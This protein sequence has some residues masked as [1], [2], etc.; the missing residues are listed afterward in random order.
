MI[1]EVKTTFPNDK[2]DEIL[3]YFDKVADTKESY[4]EIIYNY[5]TE[6]ELRLIKT[7]DVI[8]LDFRDNE[9]EDK[10]LI[11]KKFEKQL[12]KIFNNIGLSIE[13]KRFR[14]R[15]KYLYKNLYITIDNNIK[16]G[17]ILRIRYKYNNELEKEN[18]LKLIDSILD[19]LGIIKTSLDK[20]NEIYSKYR[21]GWGDLV[22]DINEE[23]FLNED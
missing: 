22:K 12:D 3:A 7:K 15:H 2:L 6:G 23:E 5:H 14:K 19:E 1:E 11:A 8:K 21:S 17:N 9:T 20:F 16:T 18:N 10:V 4:N 13:Y